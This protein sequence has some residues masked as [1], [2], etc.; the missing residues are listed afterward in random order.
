VIIQSIVVVIRRA[1]VNDLE[2]L[3]RV[4]LQDEGVTPGYRECWGEAERGAHRQL[5]LSFISDGGASIADEDGLPVGAILW[6]IRHV[7]LVEPRS[8]FRELDPSVFPA[9]GAFAEIYQLWVDPKHRR[10]GIGTALK[11]SIETAIRSQ[12]VRMIYTHTEAANAHVLAFNEKLGY[13]EVRRGP[14]WDEVVRVS[15]V[16]DLP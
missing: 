12:N 13:R 1:T 5:I 3:V 6:R 15:L 9:D 7:E 11:Q 8:V 16:K 10:G 2:L 4:D 14:I